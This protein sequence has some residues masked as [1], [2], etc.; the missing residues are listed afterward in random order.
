MLVEFFN[1]LFAENAKR[2]VNISQLQE[3][4]GVKR[5]DDLVFNGFQVYVGNDWRNVKVH[6]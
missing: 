6:I 2:V 1:M 3:K 5:N 4:W